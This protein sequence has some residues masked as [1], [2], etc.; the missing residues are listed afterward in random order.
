M[1]YEKFKD[2]A[3]TIF[4]SAKHPDEVLKNAAFIE[5]FEYWYNILTND[6]LKIYGCGVCLYEHYVQITGYTN[7]TV[8]TRKAM[9]QIIIKD[10]VVYFE[11]NHYSRKSPHLT[12]ELMTKIA[13]AYPDMVEPNPN[14][15][16]GKPV[17]AGN[18]AETAEAIET[19]ETVA[20]PEPQPKPVTPAKQPIN[21]QK[22]HKRN[23]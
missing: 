11:N 4:R 12:D 7:D 23:R 13:K 17:E 20:L 15:D 6:I 1:A 21:Q 8:Q 22:F 14:Y 9:K 19:A 18:V 2:Q 10:V 16:A 5:Q 3:N